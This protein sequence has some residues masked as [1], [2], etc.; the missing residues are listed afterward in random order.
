VTTSK[1]IDLI[2]ARFFERLRFLPIGNRFRADYAYTTS[3][4][5]PSA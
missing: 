2:E 1:D 4:S 3:D 5:R